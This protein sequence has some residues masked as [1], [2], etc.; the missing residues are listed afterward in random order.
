MAGGKKKPRPPSKRATAVLLDEPAEKT[1]QLREKYR[2]LCVKYAQLVNK[3]EIQRLE[4]IAVYS[5]ARWALQTDSNGIA[6]VHENKIEVHNTHFRDLSQLQ[7]PWWRLGP[8]RERA[9][10]FRN[11]REL[12]I[13]EAEPLLGARAD[14]A[15]PTWIRRYA[16]EGADD[17]I[18]VRYERQ[19]NVRDH[20]PRITAL[21]LDVTARAGA[22]DELAVARSHL[23][24]HARLR[25]LGELA[26]GMAHD[27]NNTLGALSLRVEMLANDPNSR[28][29]QG[30]NID[31]IQ[32][33]CTDAAARVRRLQDFGRR[34]HD[35]PLE[36]IDIAQVAREAIELARPEIDRSAQLDGIPLTIECDVGDLPAVRGDATDLRHVFINLLL[37]ARDAMPRGGRIEIHARRKGHRIHIDVAD[38]GTGIPEAQLSRIFDPFFTTKGERGTGLGLAIAAAVLARHEGQITARNRPQGGALFTLELPTAPLKRVAA[39]PRPPAPAQL[40]PRRVLIIDDDKEH[41][42]ATCRVL[43][44][45]GQKVTAELN[46]RAAI[47]RFASGEIFDIVLCDIGMPDLNGWEVARAIAL[48]SPTTPI[49]MISGWANEIDAKDPRRGLVAGVIA[50]PV[51]IEM[52]RSVLLERDDRPLLL[53]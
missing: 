44:Q 36:I 2:V 1:N 39:P 26:S 15:N 5:L 48:T 41:L 28:R 11:L 6:V 25:A 51:S 14:G 10:A 45:A 40:A 52:L 43:E 8:E 53:S 32:R 27:L 38:E 12:V 19:R 29:T 49:Y 24:D 13:E 47:A 20:E 35:H 42:D 4:R 21:V 22:E 30:A 46:G 50:K 33:I 9:R 17:I 7:G 23:D 16:R 18:E 34:R 37:N 3:F 31:A